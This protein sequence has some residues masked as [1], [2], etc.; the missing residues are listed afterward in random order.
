[1]GYFQVRYDSRVINYDCRGTGVCAMVY[2]FPQ[3][4]SK[5]L[6]NQK[7]PKAVLSVSGNSKTKNKTFGSQM[8]STCTLRYYSKSYY[9]VCSVQF[10]MYQSMSNSIYGR[11]RYTS[12]SKHQRTFLSYIL[13]ILFA[14]L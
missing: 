12:L 7:A 9:Q 1:M 2:F 13:C 14:V 5:T 11:T 8:L 3:V 4:L 10:W 6:L